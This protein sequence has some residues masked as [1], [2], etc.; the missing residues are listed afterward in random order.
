[1]V[2]QPNDE[3]TIRSI[4]LLSEEGKGPLPGVRKCDSSLAEESQCFQN[5]WSA[6]STSSGLRIKGTESVVLIPM[7]PTEQSWIFCAVDFFLETI[8][9]AGI[10]QHLQGEAAVAT[11]TLGCIDAPISNRIWLDTLAAHILYTYTSICT[12]YICIYIY[13]YYYMHIYIPQGKL[14]EMLCMPPSVQRSGLGHLVTCMPAARLPRFPPTFLPSESVSG[15]PGR[16][17]LSCF[18]GACPGIWH[19]K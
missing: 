17:L 10:Y 16:M 19:G 8:R 4:S 9:L 6:R 1:M 2:C 18:R 7:L 12:I 14:W 11:T 15:R 13:I 5:S 3:Y